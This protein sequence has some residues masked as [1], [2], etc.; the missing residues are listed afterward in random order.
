MPD[1]RPTAIVTG[2]SRGIGKA[3]AIRLLSSGYNVILNYSTDESGASEALA[4][5]AQV[6]Q[7]ALM[8]KADISKVTETA[9]LVTRA[10][11]EFGSLDVLI[12][13]AATV[14]DSS[15]LE[16]SE[17]DWDR[18][19]DVNMKGAFLCS[20]SAARQMLTQDNGGVILNIG[21]ATGIRA[22]RNGINTCAS[23]AG[24]MMMTQSLALELAPKV[25][26]NTIIPGLTLTEE[27]EHRFGLDDP[28]TRSKRAEAIPLGRLGQPDDIADAAMLML[29]DESRFITG[30]KIIVDGGQYMF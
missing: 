1:T 4:Q 22:R 10:V 29:A 19:I 14:A 20:Q 5:C 16:M 27:T 8:V 24:L 7:H 17:H 13:N 30:Q 3:I 18:V 11:D 21:A 15:M 23:K 2:S 26:V 28:A 6:S 9:N 25:R 12:N